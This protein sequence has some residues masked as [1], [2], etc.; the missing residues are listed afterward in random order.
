[1]GH[2]CTNRRN[3][4]E[5]LENYFVLKT[6]KMS[7]YKS[8]RATTYPRDISSF[9]PPAQNV[10]SSHLDE[11]VFT[12]TLICCVCSVPSA[13][14]RLCTDRQG[15]FI[16][17]PAVSACA[18]V[19]VCVCAIATDQTADLS[20]KSLCKPSNCSTLTFTH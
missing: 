15:G 13:P 14:V 8:H 9:I 12:E 20:Y 4:G 11:R 17:V 16:S 1:M 19:Y 5:K 6:L 18:C 3:I 10:L 2:F 7:K